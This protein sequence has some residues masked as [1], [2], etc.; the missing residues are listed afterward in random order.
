MTGLQETVDDGCGLSPGVE[1][2][3]LLRELR[4][5]VLQLIQ[6]LHH[7]GLLGG[8]CLPFC[9]DLRGWAAPLRAN[10]EHVGTGAVLE[11]DGSGRVE[12]LGDLW[13]HIDGQFL[14]L[15]ELGVA[16]VDALVDPV[17]ERGA[18]KVCQ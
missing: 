1:L 13:V 16:L 4:F 3:L 8:L 10:L 6:L 7:L 11:R 17:E 2:L 14:L 5:E 18:Y 9:L 15:D 12:R